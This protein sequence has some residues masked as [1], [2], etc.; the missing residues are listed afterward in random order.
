MILNNLNELCWSFLGFREGKIK[1]LQS[2]VAVNIAF[3]SMLKGNGILKSAKLA[4]GARGC[5]LAPFQFCLRWAIFAVSEA[6]A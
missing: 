2:T 4:L 3:K 1:L 6:R 5:I